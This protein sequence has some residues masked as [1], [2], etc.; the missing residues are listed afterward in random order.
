LL[1]SFMRK[2]M[3]FMVG[4]KKQQAMANS[5]HS[6]DSRMQGFLV[7]L[8]YSIQDGCR[9]YHGSCIDRDTIH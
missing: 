6:M 5:T 2:Q 1:L 3:S 7:R 8:A 9:Q 4:G